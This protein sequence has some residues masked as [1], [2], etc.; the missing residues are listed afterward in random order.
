[1]WSWLWAGPAVT[2]AIAATARCVL[3]RIRAESRRHTLE[4]ALENATPAERVAILRALRLGRP[5]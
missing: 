1:M 5:D 4:I 3:A 2:A